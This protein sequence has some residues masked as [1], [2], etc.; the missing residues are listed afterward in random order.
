MKKHITIAIFMAAMAVLYTGCNEDNN[1]N[2]SA[3]TMRTSQFAG[4]QSNCTNG[5]VKV[6]V[7]VDGTVDETQTQY[8]CN[9]ANGQNGQNGQGGQSGSNTTL[10]TTP[11]TDA[12][13][14]CANGGIKFEVLVDGVVDNTQTQYICNGQ[15]YKRGKKTG[16]S[17]YYSYDDTEGKRLS[18]C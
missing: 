5:G 9:G 15:D 4:S 17:S 2:T 12:Q 11:F 14:G 3:T 8:L 18:S 16:S 10:R 7:L 1:N 6:E 13:G